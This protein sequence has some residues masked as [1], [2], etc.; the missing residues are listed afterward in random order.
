MVLLCFKLLHTA[1]LAVVASWLACACNADN[2][3]KERSSD[4]HVEV[5][6]PSSKAMLASFLLSH[7]R[8]NAFSAPG[9]RVPHRETAAVRQ[10]QGATK[11]VDIP[12]ITLP[13]A[14]SEK[15]SELDLK[16]PNEL[17]NTDYNT[18]AGAAILGTLVFYVLFENESFGELLVTFLLSALTGGGL[19]AYL[20][21][22]DDQVGEYANQ[23]GKLLS[24]LGDLP[25]VKLPDAVTDVI[26]EQGL[27][28]PNELSTIDYNTYSSAAILGTLL[29]ILP[30]SGIVD[31][32][33]FAIIRDFIVSALI[34]GGASA[35]LS[36]RKD[37][38]GG[39]ANKGGKLV[40]DTLDKVLD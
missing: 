2:L 24:A 16:N 27:K 8:N 3:E 5:S 25:R 32:N 37:D 18:Y 20:S 40:I 22:R 33:S 35:Y 38:L 34:G 17:S 1:V 36:L 12:R 30:A 14:I 11:M 23:A 13:D 6:T 29:A 39:Y 15:L 4:A 10:R 7:S 28:N 21:L 26:K 31:I 19:G 9:M